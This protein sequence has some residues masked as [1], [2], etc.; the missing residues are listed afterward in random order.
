[1][2]KLERIIKKKSYYNLYQ[3]TLICDTA[4][5]I[6]AKID[7]Q[8]KIISFKNKILKVKC[9]NAYL[10][11]EIKIKKDQIKKTINQK[12]KK[13]QIKNIRVT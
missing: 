6:L 12:M 9:T 11:T 3:T 5:K 10:V 1:M 7:P 8:I 13:N 2:E 4:Q